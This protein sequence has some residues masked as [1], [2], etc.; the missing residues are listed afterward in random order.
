LVIC[1]HFYDFFS[2]WMGNSLEMSVVLPGFFISVFVLETF[3]VMEMVGS[4]S[5]QL[6][7]FTEIIQQSTKYKL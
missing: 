4:S 7:R 5:S 3:V 1:G 2:F 6:S